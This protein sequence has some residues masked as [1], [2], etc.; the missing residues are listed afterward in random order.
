MNIC[1]IGDGLTNLI[2]A[3]ILANK[4]IISYFKNGTEL[5]ITL[6]TGIKFTTNLIIM[7]DHR[8]GLEQNK[9]AENLGAR[10]GLKGEILVDDLLMSSIPDVYCVGSTSGTLVADSIAQE[11]GK[12]SAENAM[13]KKRQFVPEWVPIVCKLAQNVGYVGCSMRSGLEKGF[14]PV[15]GIREDVGFSDKEVETF[16]I[17]ADKRSKSVLG[18]QILS[19]QAE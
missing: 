18:S 14:H 9:L 5:E 7:V 15:E 13:G 19:S 8:K 3:K 12:V 10:L 11:Q 2:L 16:K 6:E 4:K 17:V 1:L